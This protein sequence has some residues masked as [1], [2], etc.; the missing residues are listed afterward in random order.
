MV[1]SVRSRLVGEGEK[2]DVGASKARLAP[3]ISPTGLAE[4][5]CQ[6]LQTPFMV[7]HS[8]KDQNRDQHSDGPSP[9]SVTTAVSMQ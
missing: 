7:R 8:S 9:L 6:S 2:W 5:T 1:E 3:R 4:P